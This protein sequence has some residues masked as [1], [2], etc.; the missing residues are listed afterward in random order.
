MTPV[1]ICIPDA[2][3]TNL[4]RLYAGVMNV[5]CQDAMDLKINLQNYSSYAALN[6]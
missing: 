1:F 4:M 5:P 3:F 2:Y 6:N